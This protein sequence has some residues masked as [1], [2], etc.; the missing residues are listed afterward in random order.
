MRSDELT[1]NV[2]LENEGLLTQYESRPKVPESRRAEDHQ[3]AY[4]DS[5]RPGARLSL[6]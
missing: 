4:P 6:H 2:P 1:K 3:P 5:E